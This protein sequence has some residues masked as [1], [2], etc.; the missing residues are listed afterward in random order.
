MIIVT[1]NWWLRSPNVDNANN[2]RNVNTS[3]E[4][5][6]NN[7]LNANGLVPDCMIFGEFRVGQS[8]KTLPEI[9]AFYA[10]NYHLDFAV[11]SRTKGDYRCSLLHI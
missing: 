9:K 11:T 10:R 4:L 3:G 5:N 6:N 8:C 7:A 1:R 2:V